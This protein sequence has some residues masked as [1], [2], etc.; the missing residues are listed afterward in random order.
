M[1]IKQLIS[2]I[3]FLTPQEIE[4]ERKYILEKLEK[5]KE[6]DLEQLLKASVIARKNAYI[7]YSH[8]P[9]GVALLTTSGK[10]YSGA[11]TEVVSYSQTGHAEHNAI[12]SA[13]MEGEA[14]HGRKFI[15]IL[16]CCAAGGSGPCG[17]CRQEI[18]EHADNMVYIAVDLKG[19]PLAV[20]TLNALFPLAFT[21]KHLG[22]K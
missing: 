6:S 2:K 7:P 12:N 8:Y 13:I 17:A 22:I 16:A 5:I 1:L 21:P 9:V 14:K 18:A 15:E 10:I 4:K 19:N 11:N 20:S 3:T